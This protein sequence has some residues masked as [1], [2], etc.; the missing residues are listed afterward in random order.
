MDKQYRKC[1][2]SPINIIPLNHFHEVTIEI[3]RK[4]A[5]MGSFEKITEEYWDAYIKTYNRLIQ[6]CEEL[7]NKD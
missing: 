7:W 2:E 6:K 1:A 3:L 4:S 5:F